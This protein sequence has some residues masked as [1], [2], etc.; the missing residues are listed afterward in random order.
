MI[1]AQARKLAAYVYWKSWCLH[2]VIKLVT[3]T[4]YRQSARLS[5]QSPEL[6]PPT[7][8]P[9]GECWP[10]FWQAFSPVVRIGSAHSLTRSSG[11]CCPLWFWGGGEHTRWRERGWAD[12]IRMTREKAWEKRGATL[13]CGW[14]R[15]GPNS[16]E[17]QTLWWYSRFQFTLIYFSSK[18]TVVL[19]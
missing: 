14:G 6:G 9:A 19:S 13:S 8:S 15:S 12:P 10:P 2:R 5:L 11:E 16:D 1:F 17:G 18:S 4:E 3:N 7:P